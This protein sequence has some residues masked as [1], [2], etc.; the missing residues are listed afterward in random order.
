M[1]LLWICCTVQL[2]ESRTATPQQIKVMQF[3]LRG[4]L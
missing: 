3:G 4:L 1:D 2:I